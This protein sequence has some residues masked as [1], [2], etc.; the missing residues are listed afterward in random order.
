MKKT[1]LITT[2]SC[3]LCACGDAEPPV[4]VEAFNMPGMFGTTY[5]KVEVTATDDDVAIEKVVINRGNC[6]AYRSATSSIPANL[7]FGQSVTVTSAA[8]CKL[9]EV[10]VIANGDTWSFSF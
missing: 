10:S 6:T 8:N 7:K 3:L 9:T 5:P 1:F 4:K 2:L